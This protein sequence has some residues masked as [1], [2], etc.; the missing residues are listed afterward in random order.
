[1]PTR[2]ATWWPKSKDGHPGG[3]RSRCNRHDPLGDGDP[4]H[5]LRPGRL[6]TRHLLTQDHR[7]IAFINGPHSIHACADRAQGMRTALTGAGLNPDETLVE[8]TTT[9]LN[10]DGGEPSLGPILADKNPPRRCSA[11]TTW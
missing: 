9:L 7:R 10:A 11:S 2:P 5:A 6:A 4:L 8:I 3:N 1:M